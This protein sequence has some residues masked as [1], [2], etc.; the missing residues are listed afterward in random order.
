VPESGSTDQRSSAAS[1]A[2]AGKLTPD[3]AELLVLSVLASGPAY[4]YR[5]GKRVSSLSE[6]AF[7]L[8]PAKLYPLMTGLEKQGFV[9]ASWEEVKAAGA[10]P[11]AG[12]RRRKW[13]RLSAKGQK[14]LRLRIQ[15]HRRFTAIIDAFIAPVGEGGGGD[16]MSATRRKPDVYATPTARDPIESWLDVLESM[17]SVPAARGR[18]IRQELEDHL[19]S[20]VDDLTITGM[21]EPDAVREAMASIESVHE[22]QQAEKNER[23]LVEHIRQLERELAELEA[24]ARDAEPRA[25]EGVDVA[26]VGE[27]R[28]L[29]ENLQRRLIALGAAR[30]RADDDAGRRERERDMSVLR[31][32]MT[33]AK[34]ELSDRDSVMDRAGEG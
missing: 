7:S 22:R 12:G 5:I 13:Y 34:R 31:E 21:T 8:G 10:D 26:R 1:Q 2:S 33:R 29:I 17:L 25:D 24:R 15:A 18:A 11:E 16:G 20:R 14:R 3:H 23:N 28:D 6:G 4:G 32:E 30:A 9:T 19:R 27:L